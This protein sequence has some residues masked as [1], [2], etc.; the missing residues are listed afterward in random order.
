M[1]LTVTARRS[2][3]VSPGLSA[4]AD[5]GTPTATASVSSRASLRIWIPSLPR[6][7]QGLW[8]R[9]LLG[10]RRRW[11]DGVSATRGG[12]RYPDKS[13]L[14]D[15]G[16]TRSGRGQECFGDCRVVHSGPPHARVWSPAMV[17]WEIVLLVWLVGIP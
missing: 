17:A 8:T 13:P 10:A 11:R 14:Q 2:F 7:H 16:R 3:E 12:A 15:P 4:A 1:P 5:D 6:P 9:V